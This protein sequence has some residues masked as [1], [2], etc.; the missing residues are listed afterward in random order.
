[1]P[2]ENDG[3]Q[4]FAP[5]APKDTDDE[6]NEGDPWEGQG[7]A[8]EPPPEKTDEPSQAFTAFDGRWRNEFEGLS[9]LGHLEETV[10]IPYHTFSVRTLKTGEKIR[11][12]EMVQ[13]LESSIGYARAYRAAVV[14]AGLLLVDGKPLLVGRKSESVIAQK[15]QY[16]IDNWYD[17]VIDILYD[18]INQL[19]G[20]VLQVLKELG[21]YDARREVVQVDVAE[22]TGPAESR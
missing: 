14:A 4:E 8:P 15:Y 10:R 6:W 7:D 2:D 11:I 18:K 3:W 19:E 22:V 21:V 12:I 9:Y 5:S 16:L 17:Y 1:M 20:N 13:H